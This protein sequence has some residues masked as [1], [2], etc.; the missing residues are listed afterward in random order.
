MDGQKNIYINRVGYRV[1][2]QLKMRIRQICFFS[3]QVVMHVVSHC[4]EL[5]VVMEL[6][7]CERCLELG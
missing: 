1:A 5:N 4:L 7:I 2:A 6:G 3:N